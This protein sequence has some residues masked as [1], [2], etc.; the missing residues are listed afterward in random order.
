MTPAFGPLLKHWRNLR[1]FSQ[2]SLS[3]ESGFSSRHISFLET[4]RSKPSRG[5]ILTLA[6]ALDM[7]KSAVNDALLSSGFSP[8][9]PVLQ[10]Q[11]QDMAPVHS[12][13]KILLENHMPMPAIALDGEWNIMG[14]NPAALHMVTLLPFHGS[15]NI[16]DALI[17]DDPK[18]PQ[19]LNWTDVATWTALRLQTE[20][21]KK[22][23]GAPLRQT[24]E[25]LTADP[26]LDTPQAKSFSNY[27]PVLTTR[28]RAENNILTLFTMLAEFSTVQ[29]VAMSE[30]RVELFF[31]ADTGTQK[32]FENLAT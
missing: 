20:A 30:L 8:E 6:R 24:Y 13:V 22:G 5:A 2:L 4:G 29:D 32:F 23:P 16:V 27:G 28:V 3:L 10:A 1:R 15:F 14:G 19:F 9:F 31:A 21:A 25:R 7:P 17:N 26:R 11:S 12:A 18:N